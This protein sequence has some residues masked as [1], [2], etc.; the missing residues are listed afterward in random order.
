MQYFF[1]SLS[2]NLVNFVNQSK[3]K[4]TVFKKRTK[5]NYKHLIIALPI[6][7]IAWFAVDLLS[8]F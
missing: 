2:G 1:C 8:D 6:H 4:I 5:T 3:T 7:H